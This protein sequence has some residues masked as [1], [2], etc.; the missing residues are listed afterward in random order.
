MARNRVI[1]R[2]KGNAAAPP[3]VPD[4]HAEYRAMLTRDFGAPVFTPPHLDDGR[5]V[6]LIR[7]LLRPSGL[8][9]LAC[10]AFAVLFVVK[11]YREGRFDHLWA[12]RG[13]AIE[14]AS[15]HW[16]LGDRLPPPR[17]ERNQP[18]PLVEAPPK[19]APAPAPPPPADVED[20]APEE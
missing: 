4:A 19:T 5:P 15:A 16:T 10:S 12:P 17:E 7:L 14:K 9:L 6:G 18:D 13:A 11:L 20:E 8:F 2:P 1:G 3:P